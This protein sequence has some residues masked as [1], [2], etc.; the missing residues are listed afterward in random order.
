MRSIK[1]NGITSWWTL[2]FQES[3]EYKSLGGNLNIYDK[4]LMAI[5]AMITFN[6]NI[7]EGDVVTND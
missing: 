7:C 2:H 3:G 1:D 5:G 6:L 4:F